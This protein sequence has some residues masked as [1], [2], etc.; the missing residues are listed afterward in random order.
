MLTVS[1]DPALVV[2]ILV[3]SAIEATIVFGIMAG[4]FALARKARQRNHVER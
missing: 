2:V 4:V 3:G 1:V